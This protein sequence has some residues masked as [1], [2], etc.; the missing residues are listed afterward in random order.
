VTV[1]V[2]VLISMELIVS[3]LLVVAVVLCGDPPVTRHEHADE[4][5]DGILW[6]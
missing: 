6:H 4:I 1:G 5:R 3:V 2:G